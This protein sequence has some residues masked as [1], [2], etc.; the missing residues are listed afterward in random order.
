MVIVRTNN[1]RNIKDPQKCTLATVEKPTQRASNI[2][3]DAMS[4][5]YHG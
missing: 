5:R 1:K 3:S 2:D 4:W